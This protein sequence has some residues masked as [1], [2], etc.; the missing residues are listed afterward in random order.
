MPLQAAAAL[1]HLSRFGLTGLGAFLPDPDLRDAVNLAGSVWDGVS[2]G[3]DAIAAVSAGGAGL[4][5]AGLW[6][7]RLGVVGGA[8]STGLFAAQAWT[9]RRPRDRIGYGDA[10]GSATAT[11]GLATAGGSL[12]AL[13]ATT[14]VIPPVGLTLIAVGAGICVAGY[15][16]RAPR[17]VPGRATCGQPGA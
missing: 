13:G 15:L 17:V 4:S 1:R 12:V 2:A 7:A 16:V 11:V 5:E 6:A 8:I 9:A 3:R 14:A 10:A